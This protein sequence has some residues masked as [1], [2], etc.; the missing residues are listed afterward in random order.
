LTVP[1][2]TGKVALITGGATGVGRA[3][4]DLLAEAGA[5]IV[6]LTLSAPGSSL[7]VKHFAPPEALDR[8]RADAKLWPGEL[9]IVEGDAADPAAIDAALQAATDLGDTPVDVLILNAATNTQHPIAG[10]PLESWQRV[11]DV[12]VTG[13]FLAIR[14]C[15]PGM[16]RAGWGRIVGIASSDAHEGRAGYAAY[17]A[18]KHA[19]LGL[20]RSAALEL[21]GSGIVVVSVS[22]GWIDTPSARLHLPEPSSGAPDAP[23]LERLIAPEEVAHVVGFAISDWGRPMHG[24]DIAMR[25]GADR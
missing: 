25:A 17:C 1:S 8:L 15:L 16:T 13:P 20:L 24:C 18:S 5:H 6:V 23:P 21:D 4:V 2:L 22:P 19:L 12:N 10:H 3:T 11:M 14:G 7:E 9:R